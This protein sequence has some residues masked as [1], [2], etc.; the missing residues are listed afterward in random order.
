MHA[1]RVGGV[2]G[3]KRAIGV[4]FAFKAAEEGLPSRLGTGTA[5]VYAILN[6]DMPSAGDAG[7]ATD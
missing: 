2:L 3:R 7:R 1:E 6:L 5:V 4:D